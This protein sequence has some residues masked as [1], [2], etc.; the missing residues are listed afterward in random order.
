ML[1]ASNLTA[2]SKAADFRAAGVPIKMYEGGKCYYKA[3]IYTNTTTNKTIIRNN[4]YKLNVSSIT[5]LGDPTPTPTPD[6]ASLMLKVKV[7]PWTINLV[8]IIL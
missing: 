1:D 4:V 7:L 8:D 3:D 6:A 2:D 5:K